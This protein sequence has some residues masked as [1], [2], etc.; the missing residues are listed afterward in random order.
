[1]PSLVRQNRF[2]RVMKADFGGRSTSQNKIYTLLVCQ[3]LGSMDV[4]FID[5][6]VFAVAASRSY[7]SCRPPKDEHII[8]E[9]PPCGGWNGP[10]L[11]TYSPLRWVHA[12]LSLACIKKN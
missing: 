7:R 3:V 6:K 5:H 8:E 1:M 11:Q 2:N 10:N 9:I 4:G 12:V